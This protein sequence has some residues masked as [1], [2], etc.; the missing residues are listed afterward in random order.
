MSKNEIKPSN[1]VPASKTQAEDIYYFGGLKEY[2]LE[3]IESEVLNESVYLDVFAGS[4]IRFK[5]DV[6]EITEV[7]NKLNKL[8]AIKFRW[9]DNAPS[10][11]TAL[12]KNEQSGLVAQQVAENFPELVI[13]DE[14]NDLL[15]VNYSK[16]TPYLLAGIKE[17]SQ[18]VVNLTARI[19]EL[20]KKT[21][22]PN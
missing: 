10:V 19:E 15:L 6:S 2:N 13:R 22:L 3:Q 12:Q 1:V 9:N 14:K 4:D 8:D 17:L 5:T 7:L 21:H 11:L 16:V 20:E 18:Q